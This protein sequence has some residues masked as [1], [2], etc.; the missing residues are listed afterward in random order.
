ME[1]ITGYYGS[2]ALSS[3]WLNQRFFQVRFLQNPTL[4][5]AGLY[6]IYVFMYAIFVLI[7]IKNMKLKLVEKQKLNFHQKNA[8]QL[9]FLG[10]FKS[11]VEILKDFDKCY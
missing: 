5:C 9:G 11:L 2:E 3:L 1:Y 8:K 10:I 7:I 6:Y 4:T